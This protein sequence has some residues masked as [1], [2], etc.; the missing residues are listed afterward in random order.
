[1]LT[2]CNKLIHIFVGS[3]FNIYFILSQVFL[4]P[5]QPEQEH[6]PVVGVLVLVV[7]GSKCYQ[8]G[9]VPSIAQV[10]EEKVHVVFMSLFLFTTG[11]SET[12]TTHTQETTLSVSSMVQTTPGRY[13]CLSIYIYL[14]IP[15]NVGGATDALI[16]SSLHFSL[17][18]F[19]KSQTE[20]NVK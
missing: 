7:S 17:K 16:T 10:N 19:I 4:N 11:S 20:Q 14:S 5:I 15:S 18:L 1:M 2:A 3:I 9:Y 6:L 8:M 13:F 12:V